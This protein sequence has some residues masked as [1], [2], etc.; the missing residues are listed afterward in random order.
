MPAR[1]IAIAFTIVLCAVAASARAE[2]Y[3]RSLTLWVVGGEVRLSWLAPDPGSGNTQVKLLRRLNTAPSGP[4]DPAADVLWTGSLTQRVDPLQNLLPD[5]PG[6][7]RVYHYAVFGCDASGAI[8]ENTGSRAALAPSLVQC[9][10]GGGY[11]I[12]WRH[13]DADVCTDR[14]DLGTAATTSVPNWWKS[15]DANCPTATARQLNAAGVQRATEIGDRIRELG[16]PVGRVI[17]SEYC[18]CTQ[19]AQWMAF[20]PSVETEQGISFFVYD[21]VNRCTHSYDRITEVPAAGSNT[22]IIG[23]AGFTPTCPTL[24]LLAWSEC[25]VFKPGAG[26]ATLVTRLLW[27]NWG[28]LAVDATGEEI[29]ASATSLDVP[30]ETPA[31]VR[32]RYT[33]APPGREPLRL[34]IFDVRGRRLW[35][36]QPR[37]PGAGAFEATW[38]WRDGRGLEVPRGIYL[39]RL[40][41]GPEV[42]QRKAVVLRP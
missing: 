23:H 6:T 42:M 4:D 26:G 38:D 21:E 31:G 25:A 24:S 16:I 14:T 22:A 20:G 1:R 17:S 9:L 8:C 19:T 27:N 13:A 34:E 40:Q 30:Q 41:A 3:P 39:V 18:R 11:T 10:R 12:F 29:A 28:D 5:F 36:L 35:S 32:I 15:C 7:P 37:V 2:P 33:V